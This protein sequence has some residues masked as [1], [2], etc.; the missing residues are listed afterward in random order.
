[1]DKQL[2]MLVLSNGIELVFLFAITHLIHRWEMDLSFWRIVMD[3]GIIIQ[4][5]LKRAV[6]I[7]HMVLSTA[8]I[9]RIS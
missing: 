5:T 7:F 6:V 2:K 3:T 8:L 4:Y 1:M 9:I